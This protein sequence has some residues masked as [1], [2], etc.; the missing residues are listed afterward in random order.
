[1]TVTKKEE[2]I[3]NENKTIEE[4]KIS[5]GKSISSKVIGSKLLEQFPIVEVDPEDY[6]EVNKEDRVSKFRNLTFESYFEVLKK[7]NNKVRDHHKQA[8]RIYIEEKI[9]R[10]PLVATKEE[11][12]KIMESY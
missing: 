9:K 12:D 8:V 6:K 2:D 7:E 4:N 5:K 10:R 1:M 3:K 11:Y